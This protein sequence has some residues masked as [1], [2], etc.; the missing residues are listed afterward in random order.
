MCCFNFD[1]FCLV[2]DVCYFIYIVYLFRT[3]RTIKNCIII[4]LFLIVSLIAIKIRL[5]HPNKS[6]DKLVSVIFFMNTCIS[7][8]V[9]R[10]MD[11][12]IQPEES[13]YEI[14]TIHFISV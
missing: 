9:Y 11:S 7:V 2:F 13:F 10:L 3:Y 5:Q 6:Y 1:D 12:L 8:N 14:T 4:V